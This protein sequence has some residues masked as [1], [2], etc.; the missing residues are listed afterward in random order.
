ML[1]ATYNVYECNRCKNMTV[2]FPKPIERFCKAHKKKL[3]GGGD[4][5]GHLPHCEFLEKG[6]PKYIEREGWK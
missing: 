5:R 3:T 2:T 1:T 4:L 6:K